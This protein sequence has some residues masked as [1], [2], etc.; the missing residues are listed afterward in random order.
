MFLFHALVTLSSIFACTVLADI[1]CE[2]LIIYINYLNITVR[3]KIKLDICFCYQIS[4]IAN[5]IVLLHYI[6]ASTLRVYCCD[7]SSVVE[8]LSAGLSYLFIQDIFV[9]SWLSSVAAMLCMLLQM[10]CLYYIHYYIIMLH[11]T[12][13]YMHSIQR[14]DDIYMI[15]FYYTYINY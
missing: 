6:C 14:L 7:Y 2:I 10:Q 11:V 8:H 13:C 1:H 12:K 15:K 5:V 4:Y 3:S 9:V